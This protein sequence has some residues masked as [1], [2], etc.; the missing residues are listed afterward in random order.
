MD[1]KLKK[2]KQVESFSDN[3]ESDFINLRN[4]LKNGIKWTESEKIRFFNSQLYFLDD[5]RIME[6]KLVTPLALNLNKRTLDKTIDL[7]DLALIETLDMPG[8]I[9]EWNIVFPELNELAQ[10]HPLEGSN[11]VRKAVFIGSQSA[12]EPIAEGAESTPLQNQTFTVG[13]SPIRWPII[14][15]Q[16]NALTKEPEL[17][18]NQ[19]QNAKESIYKGVRKRF[20]ESLFQH[21]DTPMATNETYEGGLTQEA[22]ILTAETGKF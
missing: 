16:N 13:L 11:Y 15:L 19:I 21:A 20:Y 7:K 9:S 17:W 10:R 22:K 1:E 4:K 5:S 3:P 2:I 14:P 12:L 8:I 6:S 18:D